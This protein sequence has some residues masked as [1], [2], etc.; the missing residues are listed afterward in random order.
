[1]DIKVVS[2]NTWHGGRIFE[3]MVQFLRDQNA[4]I[5]LLQ[6]VLNAGNAALE[7]RFNCFTELPKLLGYQYAEYA[8]A[9]SWTLPEGAI[10]SG[11]A[12]LSKF[13]LKSFEPIFFNEPYRED[14]I[15]NE[16]GFKT[17]PRNLQHVEATTP[18]GPVHVF[19][20]QGVWD[21]DGDN[22]SEKRLNM[23][24][25]IIEQS[26]GLPHVVV[27]G[28]TNAKPTNKAMLAIEEHLVSVFK[29]DLKTSFNVR[30]KD[31]VKFPG[32]ATATVDLMY[33]SHDVDVLARDCPDA[34]VSDHLP[35]TATLRLR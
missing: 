26:K 24:R 18:A 12:V 33:V 35:L 34:D 17:C 31:L 2:L 10:E 1:M 13:P 20:L 15:D 4:D 11:N 29:N 23:S 28:D 7:P 5:I 21:L 14:Y 22:V 6:E 3:P 25:I 32:Y 9:F 8:P 27:A 30:R 16:E 19:N